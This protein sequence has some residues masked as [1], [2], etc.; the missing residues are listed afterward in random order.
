MRSMRSFFSVSL[1]FGTGP[2]YKTVRTSYYRAM[3]DERVTRYAE[4][5]V[6]TCIG[7]Q[8]GWQVGVCGSPEGRHRG[9]EVVRAIARRDAYP[10]L[11]IGFGGGAS[12]PHEWVLEA[13]LERLREAPPLELHTLL[14]ADALIVV[15]APENTRDI[16]AISAERLQA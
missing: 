6:D 9:E 16:S 4:L 10:L 14:N 8:P 11:R 13:P 7:V 12:G 3:R 15:Q 5:L 2:L 1:I